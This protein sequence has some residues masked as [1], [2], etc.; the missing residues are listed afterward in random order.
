MV[1]D[2]QNSLLYTR[3]LQSLGQIERGQ[4]LCAVPPRKVASLVVASPP[5]HLL[6]ASMNASRRQA[7]CARNR[8]PRCEWKRDREECSKERLYLVPFIW[9]NWW[10][11]AHQDTTCRRQKS[12]SVDEIHHTE[13]AT[14]WRSAHD[15]EETMNETM[16]CDADHSTAFDLPNSER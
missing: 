8:S 13:F 2:G 10:S 3:D 16:Y 14:T 6:N 4:N 11:R 12:E 5:G 7:Q 9:T 15:A 1:F